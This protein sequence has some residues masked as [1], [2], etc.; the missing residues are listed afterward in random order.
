MATITRQGFARDEDTGALVVTGTGLGGGGVDPQELE[1]AVA[2]LGAGDNGPPMVPGAWYGYGVGGNNPSTQTPTQAGFWSFSP[3]FIP[4]DIQVDALGLSIITALAGHTPRLGIYTLTGWPEP[5]N[6]GPPYSGE[7][8][9][10]LKDAGTV[11]AGTTGDK[12]ATFT[13][14]AVPRGWYWL[15]WA[16]QGVQGAPVYRAARSDGY[17]QGP[18]GPLG[19]AAGGS[20]ISLIHEIRNVASSSDA[21]GA[22]TGAMPASIPRHVA[23]G[24]PQYNRVTS[25]VTY[26]RAD[27]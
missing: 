15:G 22:I 11:D 2:G 16:S 17:W 5:S 12:A 7:L 24:V 14:I 21:T 19:A 18:L 10:L 8:G 3:F 20:N 1:D 27:V 25:G 9:T 6:I 23:A 26:R 13:A 4:L